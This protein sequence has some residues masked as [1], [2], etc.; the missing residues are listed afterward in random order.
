MIILAL[1][2]ISTLAYVGLIIGFTIGLKRAFSKSQ[3]YDESKTSVSV[4]V[5]FR[6][7]A[8]NLQ[9]LLEAMIH[10]TFPKDKFEVILVNDHSS[11]S[12]ISIIE[13]YC[14]L[15]ANFR[16]VN[17]PEDKHGKKA[18][19]ALGVESSNHDLIAL[20]DADCCPSEYWI[21]CIS[22][23]AKKGV[24]LILG[25]VVMLPVEGFGQKLQA[26]EY[27]SLM[28]S[29]VGSFGIGHPII[30]SS[31][32]LAFR[33]D[34]LQFDVKSLNPEVTSGDDMFLLHEAKRQKRGVIQFVNDNRA[35]VRTAAELTIAKALSQ[36][37]RW[38]SKSIHYKDFD[39]IF[40]G[41]I[42]LI[43]NLLIVVVFFA[44]FF[45]IKCFIYLFILLTIK[46]LVDYLLINRYLKFTGQEVLLKVFLPLQ[47][48]YPVY[49]VYSF[50]S[51]IF[52]KNLWKG[53]PIK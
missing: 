10:Q 47:V 26:L 16:L 3:S 20:T 30:A 12:S 53:R 48:V 27:S 44:A 31:A 22:S 51:G 45:V 2:V 34:L 29:A 41:F 21:E 37:K 49:I 43:Y 5:A 25:P 13:H 4:V 1:I 9:D 18:A 52:I 15:Y 24:A 23:T 14:K 17:L 38:A 33:N 19:V 11:D 28:A 32:N 7:E 8:S 40:V 50:L 42:V 39:T 46:T 36:R 6:D 35:I